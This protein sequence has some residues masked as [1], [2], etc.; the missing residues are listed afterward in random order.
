MS[1]KANI[2]NKTCT[3]SNRQIIT[4]WDNEINPFNSMKVLCYSKEIESILAGD[5]PNPV[6]VNLDLSNICNHDCIWCFSKK[7][8]QENPHVMSKRLIKKIVIDL[9]K[10]HVK[11]VILSG[12]GEPL[13]NPHIEYAI[14]FLTKNKIAVGLNTNGSL[15]S[16]VKLRNL[17]KL[18]YIRVS[19]DGG[20][21]THHKLHNLKDNKSFNKIVKNIKAICKNKPKTLTFGVGYLVHDLNVDEIIETCNLM[22]Q[23]QVDYL[24]I[25]PIKYNSLTSKNKEKLNQIN[26]ACLMLQDNRFKVYFV[27]HKESNYELQKNKL[28]TCYMCKLVSA[29]SPAG[30]VYPCCELRGRH[31][32]VDLNKQSFAKFWD[33]D[34]H[35]KL[36]KKINFAQCPSCKFSKQNRIIEEIFVKD[37]MHRDFL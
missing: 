34:L 35:K 5:I 12:G 33:S 14:N 10:L 32:L 24:E 31:A 28:K 30:I 25:R 18:K 15:L 11:S 26:K 20:K 23:I 8:N 17:Y 22:K 3:S 9:A 19:L 16:R 29:I 2:L 37:Y 7:Y 27:M 4:E 21:N 6:T 36:I 13:T 1:A